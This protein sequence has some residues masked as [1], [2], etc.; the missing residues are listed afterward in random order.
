MSGKFVPNL[1]RTQLRNTNEIAQVRLAAFVHPEYRLISAAVARIG[2]A[3]P[4]RAVYFRLLVRN[5][6][7]AALR[8]SPNIGWHWVAG[9]A[10]DPYDPTAERVAALRDLDD[11]M[12]IRAGPGAD[13]LAVCVDPV[14]AAN[15]GVV[16][17][18]ATSI[19]M[20]IRNAGLAAYLSIAL[21][22]GDHSITEHR[23]S[24]VAR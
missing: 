11:T 7:Q 14:R 1:G 4:P 8:T 15:A 3:T 20:R 12:A 16:I 23:S 6:G 9:R 10:L 5:D 18:P 21:I 19:A 24:T 17:S 2:D 13:G 22:S